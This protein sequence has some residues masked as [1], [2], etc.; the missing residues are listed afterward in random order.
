MRE[1]QQIEFHVPEVAKD[2]IRS[3]NR[4]ILEAYRVFREINDPAAHLLFGMTQEE[5]ALARNLRH[6]QILELS[7]LGLPLWTKRVEFKLTDP[8]AQGIL[9]DLNREAL[10]RSILQS[11]ADLDRPR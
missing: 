1:L 4:Q 2:S 7:N 5:F 8:S 3:A 9:A 6:S 10:V 11:F